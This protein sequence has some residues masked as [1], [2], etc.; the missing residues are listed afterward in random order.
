MGL[1]CLV[2][3]III[4]DMP[5]ARDAVSFFM[6]ECTTEYLPTLFAEILKRQIHCKKEY[7]SIQT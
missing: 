6:F 4:L 3:G 7:F 5:G 2:R 1:P